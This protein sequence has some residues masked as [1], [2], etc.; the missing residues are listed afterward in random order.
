LL[1]TTTSSKD[2]RRALVT[3]NYQVL[4]YFGDNLGDFT[5]EFDKQPVSKRDALAEQHTADFGNRF[6]V[7]PN[8]VYGEWANAL[9]NYKHGDS[10][11]VKADSMIKALRTY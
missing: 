6:I 1:S 2:E 9:F 8:P 7:L 10:M 3:A 4:L 11:R 5:G